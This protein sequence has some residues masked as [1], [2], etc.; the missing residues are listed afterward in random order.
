MINQ[1]ITKPIEPLLNSQNENPDM[2]AAIRELRMSLHQAV[3]IRLE[4]LQFEN[5]SLAGF[6]RSEAFSR[7]PMDILFIDYFGKLR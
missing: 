3:G 4:A 2:G 6:G 1:D 7:P 5:P